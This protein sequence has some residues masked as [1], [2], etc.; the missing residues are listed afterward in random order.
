MLR[1]SYRSDGGGLHHFSL[2]LI[3]LGGGAVSIACGGEQQTC[4]SFVIADVFH[5]LWTLMCGT[6]CLGTCKVSEMSWEVDLQGN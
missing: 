6:V 1:G 2:N 5:A 4:G 3:I